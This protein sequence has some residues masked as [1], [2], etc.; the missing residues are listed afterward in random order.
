ML[1]PSCE[2]CES[3]GGG[4][5]SDP[6][7]GNP[8]HVPTINRSARP[9]SVTPSITVELACG[10]ALLK[11]GSRPWARRRAII[12]DWRRRVREELL[13]RG[14]DRG[15]LRIGRPVARDL[16]ALTAHSEPDSS[17]VAHA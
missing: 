7:Q 9:W 2:D 11:R 10:D 12:R 3:R 16:D 13:D 14:D 15:C 17:L 8:F 4:G 5:Y 1:F 6:C